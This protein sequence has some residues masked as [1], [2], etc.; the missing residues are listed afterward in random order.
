M[1]TI[2][3]IG[4]GNMGAPMANNLIKAGHQFRIY[5]LMPACMAAVPDAKAATSAQEAVE[6][7]TVVIFMLPESQHVEA[8]YLGDQKLLSC[9][10]PDTLVIDCST[11]S[12]TTS[13]KVASAAA[14]RSIA[15]LDAP[16]SSGTNG[17]VA[18]ILTF[19]VG[20]D[21]EA[22]S[23][24]NPLLQVMG[25]NIFHAGGAGAGQVAKIAN[26]MMLGIQMAGACEA[27][28]LGVANGMDPSVLSHIMRLSSGGNWPIEKYNPWP[29]VMEGVPAAN[30][31]AGGFGVDLML[32]DLGLASGAAQDSDSA[33]ILGE[34]A[35]EIF[36]QH[37]QRRHGKRDF[38]S[39][40]LSI[41]RTPSE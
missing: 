41:R 10:A 26:N 34:T 7:A 35:R 23:T 31:F 40:L 19:M 13:R 24:A 3:F 32:K 12:P 28:A 37:S 39:V 4:V 20:G 14:A 11:I 9:I 29:G 8:L 27:L 16:V 30:E 18:G 5:D 15:M 6:G 1:A 33:S 17:A 36:S 21:A 2:A 22:L 25:K 38:S